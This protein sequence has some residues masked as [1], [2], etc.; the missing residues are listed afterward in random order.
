LTVV[1]GLAH[2]VDGSAHAAALAAG[3]RTIAVLGSG[4]DIIYPGEHRE[5]AEHITENGAVLSEFPFGAAPA[6][7]NFPKRNRIISG[8]ALCATIIE[9]R[10][11]SGALST[12]RHA[13]EQNREVFAVPGPAGS[14]LS[15]GTNNLIKAGAQLVTSVDDILAGLG[16]HDKPA[17]TKNVQPLPKLTPIQRRVYDGLGETPC[18]IDQLSVDL[19][20]TVGELSTILLDLELVGVVGQGAGKRFYRLI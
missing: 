19:A 2:G 18:H 20:L 4:L 17:S 3:G 9:A 8:L 16:F 11:I 12:A 6:R 5:L 7:E 10:E 14:E 13:L 1:S 15:V